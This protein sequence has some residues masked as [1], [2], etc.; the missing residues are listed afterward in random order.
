MSELKDRLRELRKTTGLSQTDFAEKLGC[1]RGT[2]KN[3]EEGKTDIS[4]TFADLVCRIYGCNVIWLETGDGEMFQTPTRDEQIT[5]FVGKT[6]FGDDD[7][8]FAKQ[9]LS[10][11][12]ALDDNGWKTLKAAAEVLKK[13]EDDAKNQPDE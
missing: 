7:S 10:I 3:L 4:P 8:D 2:I 5:D 11:L 1:G 6:L 12:A 9:L 13:A